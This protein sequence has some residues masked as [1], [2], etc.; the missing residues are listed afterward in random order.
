[1]TISPAF[2]PSAFAPWKDSLMSSN[3]WT[4]CAGDSEL[5]PLRLAP[6]RVVEAQHQLSTRKLVDTAE[7][8]MLL[9][10]LPEMSKPPARAPSRLHSLLSTPFRSPPL[11]HGSRFG[12]R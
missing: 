4:R 2:P 3:I 11:R 5:R 9:E 6:L 1:M 8:Q 10:E 7:E 12:T